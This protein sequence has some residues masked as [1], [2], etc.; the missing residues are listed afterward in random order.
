MEDERVTVDKHH[1]CWPRGRA[2]NF[3]ADL[4]RPAEALLPSTTP[5]FTQHASATMSS[6]ISAPARAEE[7]T[8]SW[9]LSSALSSIF[10][11]V[12]AEVS[13]GAHDW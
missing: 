5:S 9:S 1:G 13:P 3:V 4:L 2:W 7:T 10:P 12:Y 8:S 11:V 6:S